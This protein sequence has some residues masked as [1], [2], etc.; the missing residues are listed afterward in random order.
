MPEPADSSEL[1]SDLPDDFTIVMEKS[2]GKQNIPATGAIGG[3]SADGASVV[4]NLFVE[5]G[6]VPNYVKHEVK[7]GGRVDLQSGKPVSRGNLTREVVATLVMNPENALQLGK[8]L[9]NNANK[10]MERRK[11]HFSQE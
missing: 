9:V 2:D 6:S 8:W 11:Q 3:A 5:Y 10:A 4:A 1:P 7:E